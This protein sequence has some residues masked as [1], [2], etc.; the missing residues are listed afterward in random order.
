[1]SEMNVKI[2]LSP[3]IP[4]APQRNQRPH[5]LDDTERPRSGK[6]AVEGRSRARQ[7]EHQNPPGRAL[8]ERIGKEHD[9][10]RACSKNGQCIHTKTFTLQINAP[11]FDDV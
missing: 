7:R 6:P 4:P 10:N 1:M 5:A 3:P 11:L 2:L 8:L 9:G